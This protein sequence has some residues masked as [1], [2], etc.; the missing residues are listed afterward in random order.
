MQEKAGKGGPPATMHMCGSIKVTH[1]HL[2]AS[3]QVNCDVGGSFVPNT[4]VAVC[5]GFSWNQNMLEAAKI[6]VKDQSL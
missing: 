6:F 3:I 1:P 4:G 2:F 5:M